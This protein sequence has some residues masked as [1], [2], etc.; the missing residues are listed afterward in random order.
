MLC[1]SFPDKDPACSAKVSKIMAPLAVLRFPQ[2]RPIL[3]HVGLSE[4]PCRSPLIQERHTTYS[5]PN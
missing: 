5:I 1:Y 2:Q 4:I 3:H